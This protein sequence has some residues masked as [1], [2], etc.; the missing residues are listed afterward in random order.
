MAKPKLSRHLE[1]RPSLD[2]RRLLATG[3]A[4]TA[5]SIMP[6]AGRSAPSLNGLPTL[7]P[8][9]VRDSNF[10]AATARRLLEIERRNELRRAAGL[11]LLPIVQE[12]RRLKQQADAEEFE[13]FEA[14][15]RKAIWDEVLKPRREA[16]GNPNWQPSWME[17]MQYENK[18]RSLL[19]KR[20]GDGL[21]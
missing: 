7:P 1:D 12:L 14:A 11:P 10:C 18:V 5:A 13:R 2:R 4:I 15:H 20:Y 9:L 16:E 6:S 8:T 3:A 17:G 19:R 21:A